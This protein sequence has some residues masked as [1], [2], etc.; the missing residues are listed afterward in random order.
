MVSHAARKL[1][2]QLI[3]STALVI[4]ACGP[5]G[6]GESELAVSFDPGLLERVGSAATGLLVIDED[7]N[8]I[9]SRLKL[10]S[11]FASQRELVD[12]FLAA[13]ENSALARGRLDGTEPTKLGGLEPGCCW[14]I[15]T[16]GIPDGEELLI[17]SLPA[18]VEPG[19]ADNRELV[20][21]RSNTALVY[22]T[23]DYALQY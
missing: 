17:W 13:A 3:C 12:G 11:V 18:A 5:T 8:I 6:P 4:S 22:G 15:T 14:V 16:D 21:H 19:P 20:L 2:F 23:G 10:E 1:T 9:W 7:P